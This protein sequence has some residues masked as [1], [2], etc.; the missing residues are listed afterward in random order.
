MRMDIH[1]CGDEDDGNNDVNQTL[2]R[3]KKK[4]VVMEVAFDDLENR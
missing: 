2:L 4:V 3:L 1:C